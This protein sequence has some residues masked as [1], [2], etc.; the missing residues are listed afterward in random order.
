MDFDIEEQ[1]IEQLDM[2][3]IPACDADMVSLDVQFEGEND[4]HLQEQTEE[5]KLHNYKSDLLSLS[6]ATNC[7]ERAI[8]C[9]CTMFKKYGAETQSFVDKTPK[10]SMCNICVPQ[11]VCLYLR[12]ICTLLEGYS[13]SIHIHIF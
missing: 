1:P 4:D 11:E 7:S 9:F 8:S 3:D 2:Q 12:H 6:S 10:G 13:H 5:E